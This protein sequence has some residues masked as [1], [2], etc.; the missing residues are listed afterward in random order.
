M[1]AR[2]AWFPGPR[3]PVSDT[4]LDEPRA[5]ERRPRSAQLRSDVAELDQLIDDRAIF[6]APDGNLHTKQD[7]LTVHGTG[8]QV[9]TKAEEEEVEE[10]E[11][12]LTA[13][14][15]PGRAA[16]PAGGSSPPTPTSSDDRFPRSLLTGSL[17]DQ[18]V[19]HPAPGHPVSG[20]CNTWNDQ[21]VRA[22]VRDGDWALAHC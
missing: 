17:D 11:E 7:D 6:S 12:E 2:G 21:L 9:M 14:P 20:T 4:R 22:G 15:A 5:A 10:E 13:T 19:G 16:T 1:P 8:Q 3:H 18:C